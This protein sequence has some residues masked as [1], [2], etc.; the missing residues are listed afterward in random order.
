[1]SAIVT[2]LEAHDGVPGCRMVAN[3]CKMVLS[4]CI[5]VNFNLAAQEKIDNG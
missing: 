2:D 5:R 1:M 4:G 3:G